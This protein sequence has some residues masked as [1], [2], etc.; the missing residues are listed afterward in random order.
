MRFSNEENIEK[1]IE[2]VE[3][4]IVPVVSKEELNEEDVFVEEIILGLRMLKGINI[5]K[6]LTKH[7]Q[8]RID[9]FIKNKEYLLKIGLLEENDDIIRLTDRGLDLA[10][11]VFIK[12]ME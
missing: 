10:N 9:K 12:F 8:E 2:L 3:K 1:Y 4:D 11:Q 6:I 5:E 7:S